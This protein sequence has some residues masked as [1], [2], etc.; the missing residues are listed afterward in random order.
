M[1]NEVVLFLENEFDVKSRS[2]QR[3]IVSPLVGRMHCQRHFNKLSTSFINIPEHIYNVENIN[4]IIK[5]KLASGVHMFFTE[6]DHDFVNPVTN[7]FKKMYLQNFDQ[8][9]WD[10]ESGYGE[11]EMGV[12]NEYMTWAVYDVFIYTNFPDVSDTLTKQWHEVNASRGFFVSE[13]FGGKLLELYKEKGGN[14]KIID[15]YPDMLKWCKQVE[16]NLDKLKNTQ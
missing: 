11:W 4:Q 6:I 7:K 16:N 3:I 15:L 2:K 10:R 14:I 12:F 1:I 13:M 8:C 5:E 9:K